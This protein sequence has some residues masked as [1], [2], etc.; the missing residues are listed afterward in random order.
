VESVNYIHEKT[1]KKDKMEEY[2]EDGGISPSW[3]FDKK[4]DVL[5]QI[6]KA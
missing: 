4:V 2:R 5:E 6:E 3:T 1:G